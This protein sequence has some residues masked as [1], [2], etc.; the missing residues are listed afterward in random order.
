MKDKQ[1]TNQINQGFVEMFAT[2]IN[3]AAN[4]YTSHRPEK[5]ETW[6]EAT[7]DQM[8]TKWLS[9]VGEVLTLFNDKYNPDKVR[10]EILDV[11]NVSLMVVTLISD[12]P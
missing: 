6:K 10:S 12:L 1:A 4:V 7:V 2:A 8:L 3:D 9:E 11:I 5:G